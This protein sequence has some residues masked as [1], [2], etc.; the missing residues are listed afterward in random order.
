METQKTKKSSLAIS[1]LAA[2]T[3]SFALPTTAAAQNNTITDVKQAA[4]ALLPVENRLNQTNLTREQRADATA[5]LLELQKS[6]EIFGEGPEM[7][8]RFTHKGTNYNIPIDF[9]AATLR[10]DTSRGFLVQP[11]SQVIEPAH[12]AIMRDF[13]TMSSS[14]RIKENTLSSQARG[15][16]IPLTNPDGRAYVT[17]LE[18]VHDF[19]VG[20][21]WQTYVVPEL[22]R[23]IDAKNAELHAQL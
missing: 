19:D 4:L 20:H 11:T 1:A 22:T 18:D 14:Q 2:A 15:A 12:T 9:D 16:F 21:F 7:H 5:E 23:A 10:F 6:L 3:L 8:V 17:H 13:G